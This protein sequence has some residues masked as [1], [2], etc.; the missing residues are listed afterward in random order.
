M[1]AVASSI[2]VIYDWVLTFGQEVGRSCHDWSTQY[3]KT[4]ATD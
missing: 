4:V 1:F 3:T 2:A